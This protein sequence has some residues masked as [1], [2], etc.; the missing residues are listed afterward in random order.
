[1]E[2]N[3]YG[4]KVELLSWNGADKPKVTN[5]KVYD[6]YLLAGWRKPGPI[7]VPIYH[8]GEWNI[9]DGYYSNRF[10]FRHLLF[11]P[12]RQIVATTRRGRFTPDALAYSSELP[13]AWGKI[14]KI[15]RDTVTVEAPAIEGVPVSGEQTLQ[16]AADAEFVHLGQTIGRGEAIQEGRLIQVY[17]PHPARFFIDR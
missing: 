11:E 1:M 3:P 7:E 13:A 8:K 2:L 6:G 17:S 9:V 5:A 4:R 14:T 16:L 15:D 10:N 12:G